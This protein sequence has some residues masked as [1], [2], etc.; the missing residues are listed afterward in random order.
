MLRSG[1]YI[2][3][4][5]AIAKSAI[6]IKANKSHTYIHTEISL[7]YQCPSAMEEEWYSSFIYAYIAYIIVKHVYGR[8]KEKK[9]RKNAS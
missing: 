7:S 3:A 9:R 4:L 8:K 1:V 2:N 6:S 5:L